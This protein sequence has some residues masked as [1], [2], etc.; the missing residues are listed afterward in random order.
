MFRQ[1][2]AAKSNILLCCDRMRKQ[3]LWEKNDL[4]K[5]K[6]QKIYLLKEKH[7]C[8]TF[9]CKQFEKTYWITASQ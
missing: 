4:E 8:C 6:Y 9:L 5:I 1:F 2:K 7:V 3:R